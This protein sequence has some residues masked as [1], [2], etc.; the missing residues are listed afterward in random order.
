MITKYYIFSPID[1]SDYIASI[2]E[3]IDKEIDESSN[4][5]YVFVYNIFDNDNTIRPQEYI[6]KKICKVV[7]C[8]NSTEEE[9]ES[10][11]EVLVDEID[12]E[13]FLEL[14]NTSRGYI[15]ESKNKN[16]QRNEQIE[17]SKVVLSNNIELDANSI[18]LYRTTA[19]VT[20]GLFNIIQILSQ[21]D[22]GI[23]SALDLVNT[24]KINFKDATNQFKEMNLNQIAEGQRLI[25][26]S[27]SNLYDKF[28]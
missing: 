25:L 28:K 6:N 21:K 14:A 3:S 19:I 22:E 16:S 15:F 17:K 2:N 12:E 23:K 24:Q 1:K 20:A 11:L 18:S 8:G 7:F 9:W 4:N 10:S 13:K 27:L 26:E 5:T